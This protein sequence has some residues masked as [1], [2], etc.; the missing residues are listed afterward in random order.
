MAVDY[1][2]V[3]K[4]SGVSF[5]VIGRGKESATLFQQK[6]AVTPLTGGLDDFL[7]QTNQVFSHAIV[8]TGVEG[9]LNNTIALL[10]HGI[11]RVLIEKPAALNTEELQQKW[12]LLSAGSSQVFVAYN[13]RFYASVQEALRLVQADGG[14]QSMHFEFTEWVHKID[15]TKKSPAILANWFYANST[16]VVDL[17]FYIAGQPTQLNSFSKAGALPW[18]AVTNFAGAG[19][20]EKAVLFSYLSNWESA[21]RWAIELLTN[22]RRIYLKPLESIGVQWKGKI[23]I[24]PHEFDK[25]IDEDFKPG[26][27]NQTAAFLNGND[28]LL[29]TIAAHLS[30][31]QKVYNSIIKGN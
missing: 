19:I 27:Y 14:L 5:T 12:P 24:E 26:L 30:T 16:H 29:L 13:R 3:L 4:A 23:D 2:K 10:N 6:T 22:K 18:H 17:A 1:V 7:S 28:Q 9:L 11:S 25:K 20:T 21:G 8:A 15:T 31:S